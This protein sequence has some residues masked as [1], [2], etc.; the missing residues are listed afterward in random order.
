MTRTLFFHMVFRKF[1]ENTSNKPI[2]SQYNVFYK[3]KYFFSI[4]VMT[5]FQSPLKKSIKSGTM[6]CVVACLV[7]VFCCALTTGRCNTFQH[8]FA[9]QKK[10]ELQGPHFQTMLSLV[11]MVTCNLMNDVK[12]GNRFIAI[13]I[14]PSTGSR[15]Y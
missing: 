13:I 6:Q 5:S 9:N 3:Y 7:F 8:I 11:T 10:S 14:N 1:K 4:C 2:F 15:R 12:A